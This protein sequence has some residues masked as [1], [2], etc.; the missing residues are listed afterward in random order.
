LPG[1][2]EQVPDVVVWAP[3]PLWVLVHDVVVC[4]EPFGAAIAFD[5]GYIAIAAVAT[6]ITAA[7]IIVFVF[8]KLSYLMFYKKILRYF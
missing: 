1:G 7:S 3:F 8:I 6:I 5:V 4:V 2:G